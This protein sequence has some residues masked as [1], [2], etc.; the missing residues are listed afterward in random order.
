ME[1]GLCL[2]RLA[3]S[4]LQSAQHVVTKLAPLGLRVNEPFAHKGGVL[5]TPLQVA[6]QAPEMASWV[7]VLL[8]AGADA[9]AADALGDTALLSAARKGQAAAVSALLAHG[10]DPALANAAGESPVR[11][12]A[13]GRGAPP[14]VLEA[15]RAGA[16][17]QVEAYSRRVAADAAAAA[18]VAASA[19]RERQRKLAEPKAPHKPEGPRHSDVVE[20][21]VS[22]DPATKGAVAV[23]PPAKTRDE[24]VAAFL[25]SLERDV[26]AYGGI[27]HLPPPVYEE[28]LR[29]L[30]DKAPE[31]E[32]TAGDAPL[33][34]C[35]EEEE[36]PPPQREGV[37][38]TFVGHAP[39]YSGLG[40]LPFEGLL[41]NVQIVDRVRDRAYYKHSQ[42]SDA[43]DVSRKASFVHG[44]R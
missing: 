14:A 26:K 20:P 41:W 17:A 28:A 19:E 21:V 6:A 27:E 37:P 40:E 44:T 13:E 3:P 5:R 2:T 30:D 43:R 33:S 34:D 12:A 9:N 22:P 25:T 4:L 29:T 10:A 15:I 23:V 42:M 35:E 1:S 38:A 8:A 32:E 7:G 36:E 16:A 18:A 31:E 24:A 11:M 39:V